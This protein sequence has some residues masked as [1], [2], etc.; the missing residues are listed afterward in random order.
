MELARWSQ[1]FASGQRSVLS[2]VAFPFR[3]YIASVMQGHGWINWR[4]S[5]PKRTV[6]GWRK[7][8]RTKTKPWWSKRS[9]N[10]EKQACN[11]ADIS[12]LTWFLPYFAVCW[13]QL[14]LTLQMV[15]QYHDLMNSN[16]ANWGKVGLEWRLQQPIQ[17][18]LQPSSSNFINSRLP[19]SIY[20]RLSVWTIYESGTF[21]IW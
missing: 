20:E 5:S 19:W 18:N 21:C 16:L 14:V 17:R 3:E 1:L 11:K 12:G 13:L 9:T 6:L 8:R 7:Q 15:L 2:Y 4:Q 10:A